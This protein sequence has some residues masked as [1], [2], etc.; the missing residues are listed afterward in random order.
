M[1]STAQLEQ[2]HPENL[3]L[4]TVAVYELD[5]PNNEPR[6]CRKVHNGLE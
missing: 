1:G 6:N 3:G 5:E 2:I 4:A